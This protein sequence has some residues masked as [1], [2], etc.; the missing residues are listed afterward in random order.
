[1]T[2]GSRQR[3]R[4]VLAFAHCAYLVRVALVCAETLDERPRVLPSGWASVLCVFG[5]R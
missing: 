3:A 5:L 4:W 2:V 1:M